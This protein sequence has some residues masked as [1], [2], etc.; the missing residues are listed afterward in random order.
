[1]I[2]QKTVRRPRTP[3]CQC[4]RCKGIRLGRED[5]RPEHPYEGFTGYIWDSWTC[6]EQADQTR[7]QNMGLE[8]TIEWYGEDET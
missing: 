5:P 8:F 2:E 3:P 4:T 7:R 1:M 6:D